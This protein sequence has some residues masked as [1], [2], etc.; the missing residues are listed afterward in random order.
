MTRALSRIPMTVTTYS[1]CAEI[2]IL[3]PE[4]FYLDGNYKYYYRDNL[5]ITISEPVPVGEPRETEQTL[6]VTVT[7]Y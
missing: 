2:S 6:T 7:Y 3:N 4:D 1:Q 5:E